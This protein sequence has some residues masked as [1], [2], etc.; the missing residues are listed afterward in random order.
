MDRGERD[1]RK[2]EFLRIPVYMTLGARV[3][4]CVV[5]VRNSCVCMYWFSV[6]LFCPFA[7]FR[8]RIHVFFVVRAYMFFF[9]AVFYKSGLYGRV[10]R[11]GNRGKIHPTS[12]GADMTDRQTDAQ[13]E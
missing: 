9:S 11:G 4:A 13:S 3:C 2:K 1:E 8:A 6:F 12:G 5:R 10:Q 7:L